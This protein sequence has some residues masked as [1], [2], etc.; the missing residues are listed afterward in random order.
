MLQRIE[1]YSP[2]TTRIRQEV[3]HV[4]TPKNCW[5]EC[6]PYHPPGSFFLAGQERE[7]GEE[8]EKSRVKTERALRFIQPVEKL[9]WA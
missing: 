5:E 8:R 3:L 4:R 7:E 9:W 6:S 1:Q 2:P